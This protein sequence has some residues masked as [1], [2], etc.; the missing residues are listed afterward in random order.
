MDAVAALLDA[1][2]LDE[3][4]VLNEEDHDFEEAMEE[5]NDQPAFKLP[6]TEVCLTQADIRA[7]QLAKAAIHGGMVTLMAEA[8]IDPED[9]EELIIA[10]GFGSCISVTSAERIGLIPEGFAKK[11]RAIGN[12]AGAGAVMTLLS[13]QVKADTEDAA[14]KCESVELATHPVF[15]A[16]Y[17]ES[18][19]FE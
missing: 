10:G 7:V 16:S 17:V 3:T 9:V 18:M 5:I 6:G 13:R 14:Q 1:G 2:I 19:M 8:G 11:S 4:G 12:A 15:M